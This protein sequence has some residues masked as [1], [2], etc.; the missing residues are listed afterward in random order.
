MGLPHVAGS[1]GIKEGIC[2]AQEQRCC[3][4]SLKF[5]PWREVPGPPEMCF[6]P[7]LLLTSG[8]LTWWCEQKDVSNQFTQVAFCLANKTSFSRHPCNASSIDFLFECHFTT[9]RIG[10]VTVLQPLAIIVGKDHGGS[11]VWIN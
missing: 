7:R 5:S 1:L 3:T 4:N 11:F 6:C 10:F 8:V 9:N 2:C